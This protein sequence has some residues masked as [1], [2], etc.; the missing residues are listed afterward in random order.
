MRVLLTTDTVGGVW[1]FT[2]ELAG[3]LL[4]HDHS[5]ALV[6]FG[7]FPS[8][9]QLGWCSAALAL[10]PTTFRY[11]ASSA[12]L[13]WMEANETAY[14]AG[15]AL[16]LRV[17]RDFSPD[18]LHSN[19]FC[20]G[21]LPVSIPKLITAHSDVLSWSEACRPCGLQ[22]SEWLERYC[23]FVQQGLAS[24]D[25]VVAP[26][27]WMLTALGRNFDLPRCQSIILNGRT[28][29]SPNLMLPRKLQAVSV[30][31]LWDEGK[32][33]AALTGLNS[34]L[35]I[36]VAGERKSIDGDN[37]PEELGCVQELG[38]LDEADL[39]KLFCSSSIY[40]AP[41]IY[42]PFGLAPLE[43]ALCGCAVL[44][45]DIP[46]LREV[47]GD[48]IQYFG[49]AAA[50]CA[51]LEE[52]HSSPRMLRAARARSLEH[53]RTLNAERMATEYITL[54][55]SL[56]HENPASLLDRVAGYEEPVAYAS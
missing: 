55:D 28:L 27:Q 37:A 10:H 43:A 23:E 36:L 33:L 30:G 5:V 26:T 16:L 15:E 6:S 4:R 1:T 14:T 32:N 51:L 50:L 29:S 21:K 9:E 3:K 8:R 42:E 20:F 46:S 40:I 41:S 45:N 7:R 54:Y 38:F 13:E 44:A 24:A 52:L 17:A 22:P 56:L 11:E 53:A 34:P 48:A 12:P 35:R 18:V 31:R 19:Q 49:D 25:A 2:K 39:I 47:W